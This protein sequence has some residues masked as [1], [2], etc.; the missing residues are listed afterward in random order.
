MVSGSFF[1][2]AGDST[3]KIN[4]HFL[5]PKNVIIKVHEKTLVLVVILYTWD[6]DRFRLSEKLNAISFSHLPTLLFIHSECHI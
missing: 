5:K 2:F 1:N 3:V 6:Q 4:I